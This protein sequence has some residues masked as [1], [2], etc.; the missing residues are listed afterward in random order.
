MRREQLSARL[1][2]V[3][4]CAIGFQASN[5]RQ[6]YAGAEFVKAHVQRIQ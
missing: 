6:Q 5:P 4:C 2:C 1:I 3:E